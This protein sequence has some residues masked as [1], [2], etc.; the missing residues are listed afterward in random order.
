M[1]CCKFLS[2][3]IHIPILNSMQ[4][5]YSVD[6]DVR[7]HSYSCTNLPKLPSNNVADCSM[8]LYWTISFIQSRCSR[9]VHIKKRTP[10]GSEVMYIIGGYL[11]QSLRVVECYYPRYNS[12][13]LLKS[14]QQP[15]SGAG[16][17]FVGK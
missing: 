13:S 1:I 6:S 3:T 17:A 5:V 14:L 8:C 2:T 9:A 4:S 7:T 12:W 16:A 10:I 15:R 11:G